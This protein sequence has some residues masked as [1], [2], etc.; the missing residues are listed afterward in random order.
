MPDEREDLPVKDPEENGDGAPPPAITFAAISVG[1]ASIFW[2]L[3]MIYDLI[4]CG[5]P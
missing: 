3:K 5:C 1:S 4:M 2:I